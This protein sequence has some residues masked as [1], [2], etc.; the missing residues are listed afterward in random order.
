MLAERQ[1][2]PAEGEVIRAI[3]EQTSPIGIATFK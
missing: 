3:V 2:R 1:C